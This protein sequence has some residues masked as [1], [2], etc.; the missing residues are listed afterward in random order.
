MKNWPDLLTFLQEKN[1]HIRE[2]DT[3]LGFATYQIDLSDWKLRLGDKTPCVWIKEN[4]LRDYKRDYK[5][6]EIMESIRDIIRERKWGFQTLLILHDGDASALATAI[7]NPLYSLVLID[8]SAQKRIMESRRP[9]GEL[10]DLVSTQ[11]NITILSPYET[12]APVKGS[13]FFGREPQLRTILS[14]PDTNFLILGIRRIGKTSLLRE[15]ERTLSDGSISYP[16]Y[17]DCSD[18]K[19]AD[20]YIQQIV[21]ELNS[22][23]LPRLALQNYAFFFPD[24]LQRM[25]R[26]YHKKLVFLLDEIDA[27]INMPDG[28]H[29]FNMLRASSNKGACQYVMAGF[30][31]AW[32]VQYDLNHPFFNFSREI[33]LNE[34]QRNTAAELILQPMESLRIQ[35]KNRDDIISRIY[36]ETAGHPNL[37]QFYCLI[38]LRLLEERKQR[39][40]TIDLLFEVQNDPELQDHLLVSFMHNTGPREKAIVYALLLNEKNGS[41]PSNISN[42]QI[43]VA[44][45]NFELE[46]TPEEIDDACKFLALAGIFHL[47]GQDY[48]FNN[49][50]FI[51]MLR[52]QYN[53]EYLIAKLKE[54]KS[55]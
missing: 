54:K 1:Y 23:E 49:P 17:L 22:M 28:I 12:A 9:T 50:V 2:D 37:I 41:I 33:R 30:R 19:T 38:L 32:D 7:R 40:I 8:A 5:P 35:F 43:N 6:V 31:K 52:R 27:L 21:R 44:L 4:D 47:N 20:E 29:L 55:L 34:F 53:L 51:R 13:R 46:L 25:Q 48:S 14:N 45:H 24:F 18:I 26:K 3:T 11:V 10:L 42:S 16:V 15:V 39:L 36:E